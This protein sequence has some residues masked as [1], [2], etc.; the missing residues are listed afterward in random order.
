[1]VVTTLFS[2][3]ASRAYIGAAALCMVVGFGHFR[4]ATATGKLKGV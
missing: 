2:R 1:V 3:D 4:R